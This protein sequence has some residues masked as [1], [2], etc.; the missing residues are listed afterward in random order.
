[1]AGDTKLRRYHAAVWDEPI[2]MTMGHPGRRGLVF[3]DAEPEIKRTLGADAQ[4]LI[5]AAMRRKI[6][7]ALPQ[8]SEHEVLRHYLHLSQETLGMM[9]INLFGT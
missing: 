9:G 5:P 4:S 3:A 8:M 2:I 6:P 7:P 1:M